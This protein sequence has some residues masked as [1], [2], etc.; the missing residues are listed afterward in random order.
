MMQSLKG[1]LNRV[2]RGGRKRSSQSAQEALSMHDLAYL[3]ALR[4]DLADWFNSKTALSTTNLPLV[5]T[6]ILLL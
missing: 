6:E 4:C 5:V 1:K 3:Q 2:R